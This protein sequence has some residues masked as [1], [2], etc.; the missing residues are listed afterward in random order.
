MAARKRIDP[1]AKLTTGYRA[2]DAV[3]GNDGTKELVWVNPNDSITG[4][5]LYESMGFEVEYYRQ[6]GPRPV[7]GI[8]K[9]GAPITCMG[10]PVLMSR[11]IEHFHEAQQ[12]CWNTADMI[13]KRIKRPDKDREFDGYRGDDTYSL[14]ASVEQDR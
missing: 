13:A 2:L 12:A 4:Q 9:E 3:R 8:Y 1:P 10:G 7:V 14:H 6:D 5:P 11:P